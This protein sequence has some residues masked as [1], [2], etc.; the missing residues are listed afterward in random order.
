MI[1][2]ELS[3]KQLKQDTL[4]MAKL[5]K[6][7]VEKNKESLDTWDQDIVHEIIANEKRVDVYDL[8]ITLDVE[9][10][11]ALYNPVAVDLRFVLSCLNTA[12]NLER[13]GDNARKMANFVLEFEKPLDATIRKELRFDEM[14]DQT[15]IMMS[16][17]CSGIEN[18]D[19][20]LARKLFKQDHLLNE[21]HM[22]SHKTSVIL[23]RQYPE[24]IEQTLYLYSIIKKMER[25]GDLCKNI[26]EELIFHIEAKV[27]K[28]SNKKK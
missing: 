15:L 3:L 6:G 5:V 28:H 1:N 14:Y 2:L 20:K 12:S 7:Q 24:L 16:E 13:I 23:F 21:I 4:D 11:L 27:V 19:T 17:I 10:I 9:N 25:I 22:N 18:E 26:A 8:K